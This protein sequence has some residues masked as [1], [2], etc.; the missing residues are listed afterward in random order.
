MG[1]L[2]T[3]ATVAVKNI[4]DLLLLFFVIRP[5]A[6]LVGLAGSPLGRAEKGL[7]G[8]FG[9][10]GIASLYY[11]AYAVQHGLPQSR[12][13]A[14]ANTVL[15]TIRDFNC[16]AWNHSDTLDELVRAHASSGLKWRPLT[17]LPQLHPPQ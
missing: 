13:E 5:L 4:I 7:I 1:A 2:L 6:I 11:L 17:R 16:G 10:R 9:I 3:P 8:W 14:V 12:T 15:A